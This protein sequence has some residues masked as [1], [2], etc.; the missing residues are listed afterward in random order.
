MATSKR[1]ATILVAAGIL[2]AAWASGTVAQQAQ[3]KSKGQAKDAFNKF[4]PR[5]AP[6][7]GQ[8]YL[9]RYVGD[10]AVKKT[11]YPRNG[12]PTTIEGECRQAMVHDGRFLQS[13]FTFRPP[14]SPATEGRGLIGWE[15][16]SGL[17]T[18][19][20]TDSRQTRMSLRRSKEKFDGDKIV[21]HSVSLDAAEKDPRRSKTVS[22][23]DD[24]NLKI[25][26]RQYSLGGKDEERLVMELVMTK[27]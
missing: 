25:T 15:P 24:K 19:I 23:I 20:W 16:D 17:F 6:G 14:G 1:L 10:W 21:L 2:G 27:K 12:Q 5:S 4:E 8:A 3:E 13:D 7:A 22:I 11:F 26:H 9:R 18:S